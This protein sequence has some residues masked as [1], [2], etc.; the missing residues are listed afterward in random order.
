MAEIID[1]GDVASDGVDAA[2]AEQRYTIRLLPRTGSRLVCGPVS[3]DLAPG[4]APGCRLPLR[5]AVIL[6]AAAFAAGLVVFAPIAAA[7][8][9]AGI[10]VA[11]ALD[12]ILA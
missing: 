2:R 6:A 5:W 10:T 3:L 1:A 12:Q 8:L 11:I 4:A 9:G 7:A